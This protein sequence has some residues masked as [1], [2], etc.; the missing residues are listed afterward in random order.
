MN[1]QRSLCCSP[2]FPRHGNGTRGQSQTSTGITAPQGKAVGEAIARERTV[3]NMKRHCG[4][5]FAR[6]AKAAL[7]I[8]AKE[9]AG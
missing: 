8:R 1:S 4:D 5:V 6:R 2:R 7:M 3:Q 9:P